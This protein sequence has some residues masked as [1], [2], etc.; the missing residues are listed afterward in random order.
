MSESIFDGMGPTIF[1]RIAGGGTLLAIADDMGFAPQSFYRLV[2][3][4]GE[5]RRQLLKDARK[6]A[7]PI[8]AETSVQILDDADCENGAEVALVKARSDSRWRLAKVYDRETFGDQPVLIHNE[9]NLG[10]LHLDA[11]R[12]HG[13]MSQQ[14]IPVVEA[15]VIESVKPERLNSGSTEQG[16]TEQETTTHAPARDL[17]GA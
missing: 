12:Q 8:H 2:N 17:L 3:Q 6:E 16:S 15:R 10:S 14:A 5:E 4:G 1:E 9:L 7:A 13:S 11:L